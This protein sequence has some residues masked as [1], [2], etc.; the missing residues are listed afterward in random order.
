[1]T[2]ADVDRWMTELSNWGRW[3]KDDQLGALNLITPAKRKSAAS[4]VKEGYSV[5]LAHDLETESAPDNLSPFV[6]TMLATGLDSD[7]AAVDS[8]A[9]TAHGF[10][11]THLDALCHIFYRGKMYNG[12]SKEKVTRAGAGKNSIL[13]AKNGII[14]RGI[15]IDIPKLK[16]VEYLEPG[17]AIYSEDLDAWIKRIDVHVT[18]GDVI[19]I[20]TGRWARRKDKGPWSVIMSSPGLHASTVKWIHDHNVSMLGSDVGSDVIPSK[21]EGVP[22]PIH[23][24]VIVALGVPIFDHCDLESLSKAAAERNR[25]VFMLTAAPMAIPGGTGSP[26]NPVATF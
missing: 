12:Y 3:G 16:G 8:Y 23:Q 10:A 26:L 18:A 4:L 11:Q 22:L 19:F 5:S 7:M 15:L 17:T 20:R 14:T 2:K 9:L 25:Y 1:M 21:V 13:N 24:M 6:H